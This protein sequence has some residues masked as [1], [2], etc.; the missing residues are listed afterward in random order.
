MRYSTWLFC[1]LMMLVQTIALAQ[2][3]K[4]GIGNVRGKVTN[5]T[6]GKNIGIASLELLAGR[7]SVGKAQTGED[8]TFVLD[9]I[10][11]GV[12]DLV[13]TAPNHVPQ[14]IEGLTVKADASK[15][16]Y[17][18]MRQGSEKAEPEVVATYAAV[19]ARM[20]TEVSSAAQYTSSLFD[21]PAN[22]YI[23]NK[24]DIEE[25]GYMTLVELLHDI[26]EIEIQERGSSEY[27]NLI[28]LRGVQGS[29]RFLL[30]LDGVR[31]NSLA[32]SDGVVDKNI[33]IRYAKQVE[34]I[35][36][37]T[38]AIYGA[39]A[40]SGVINIVSESGDNVACVQG[41]ASAGLYGTTDNAMQA[42][43]NTKHFSVNAIGSYYYSQN[44]TLPKFYK[45]DYSWYNNQYLQD[46]L[47]LYWTGIWVDSNRQPHLIYDTF[48]NA[49]ITPYQA[50][51]Y[52]YYTQVN[53]NVKGFE[54][55]FQH[56][57]ESYSF[58]I[59]LRPE[60]TLLN[61]NN[62]SGYTTSNIFARRDWGIWDNKIKF[63]SVINWNRQATNRDNVYQNNFSGYQVMRR[64]SFDESIE[65]RQ[66]ATWHIAPKH[67]LYAGMVLV[68]TNA[69]AQ[70]A[71]FFKRYESGSS[72]QD[73]DIYYVGT[74]H[75]GD[76]NKIYQD[77]YYVNR[78]A[79][80]FNIQYEGQLSPKLSIGIGG[81]YDF[82]QTRQS[83]QTNQSGLTP[84]IHLIWRVNDRWRV[85]FMARGM[86]ISPSIQRSFQHEANFIPISDSTGN[87]SH[88]IGGYVHIPNP[89]LK[90]ERN[91]IFENMVSHISRNYQ[92]S[93]NGFLQ[94]SD[95][96][97]SNTY[98]IGT[99]TYKDVPFVVVEQAKNNGQSV[100]GG[101]TAQFDYRLLF[102]QKRNFEVKV[103]GAWSEFLG[104]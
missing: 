77:L 16:A 46:S 41:T 14:R 34:V 102:S 55:G 61:G 3:P 82:I 63:V 9:K 36:G 60:F 4:K 96:I 57:T 37:T 101:F 91:L 5:K 56:N 28:T 27:R 21:A 8:G 1:V 88:Y 33:S 58:A 30:L 23:I 65:L 93:L 67:V 20:N 29:G 94:I 68:N 53:F 71:G 43:W 98:A 64:Q 32:G 97:T 92:V 99:Q 95:N 70:T 52:A 79:T 26:P 48:R 13:C 89:N 10:P 15:L 86:F 2:K 51:E 45:N 38:S 74:E 22:I 104:R 40:L 7:K 35:V 83:Y 72:T 75:F 100:I 6:T 85:K 62:R 59:P 73:Q 44:P 50:P 87:F 103:Q 90:P 25:R 17:F 81:R 42:G 18:R 80:S 47:S 31:I 66:Q 54:L 76:S 12:Y 11:E 49:T 39:D 69:L 84:K 24:Q 19:Q 78:T